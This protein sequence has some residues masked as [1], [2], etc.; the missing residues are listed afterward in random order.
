MNPAYFFLVFMG[1][2]LGAVLRYAI[3]LLIQPRDDA[4]LVP[5]HTLCVNLMGSLAIGLLAGMVGGVGKLH[6]PARL[7]LV[8][9]LLGGF[10]TYSAF[11]YETF[12]LLRAQRIG[13]AAGYAAVTVVGCM[14]AVWGGWA[15]GAIASR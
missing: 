15:L 7:L 14:L 13:A 5:I 3:N 10:T 2:G 1:G 6:E 11:S 9:G 12:E 4:R 8:T